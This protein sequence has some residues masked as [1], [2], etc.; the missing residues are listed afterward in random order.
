M[1]GA[2]GHARLMP[3]FPPVMVLLCQRRGNPRQGNNTIQHQQTEI[4]TCLL[5]LSGHRVCLVPACV[6]ERGDVEGNGEGGWQIW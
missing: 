1:I 2:E 4:G 5:N 6:G 3:L